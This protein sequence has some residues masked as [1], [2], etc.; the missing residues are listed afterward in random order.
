VIA[1]GKKKTHKGLGPSPEVASE[2]IH[3]TPKDKRKEWS[4]K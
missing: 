2:F 4:K 1:H 3:A